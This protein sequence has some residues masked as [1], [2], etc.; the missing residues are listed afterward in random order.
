MKP[1]RIAWSQTAN[2]PLKCELSSVLPPENYSAL[3]TKAQGAQNPAYMITSD[4]FVELPPRGATHGD[5]LIYLPTAGWLARRNYVDY[6]YV[7]VGVFRPL[8]G[9]LYGWTDLWIDVT[10]PESG[11]SYHVLDADEFG[12]AV[13]EGRVSDELAAFALES[14]QELVQTIHEGGFPTEDIK[15]ALDLEEDLRSRSQT[16]AGA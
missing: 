4:L 14:F 11:N 16:G 8:E 13:L 9:D 7:D 5:I 10:A 6:W 1:V 15:T 12:E 2:V 3:K